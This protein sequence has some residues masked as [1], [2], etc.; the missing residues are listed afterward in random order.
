MVNAMNKPRER[1]S[2]VPSRRTVDQGVPQIEKSFAASSRQRVSL[3][4]S[5]AAAVA[6]PLC[7]A[8][9]APPQPAFI[10]QALGLGLWC[11]V[12]LVL[13]TFPLI[14]AQRS[15]AQW[16][17]IAIW[18][19][20]LLGVAI[21]VLTQ[22]SPAFVV[23]PSAAALGM[24]LTIAWLAQRVPTAWI[25]GWFAACC[26][27]L[28]LAAGYNTFV[29]GLQSVA[30]NWYDEIW[31]A[32]RADDR[33]FGNLRQ[34]NLLAT[35]T[36]WGLLALG[37]LV[38]RVRTSNAARIALCLA[39]VA[40]LIV[41]AATGSRSGWLGLPIAFIAIMLVF[42]HD[43]PL[44]RRGVVLALVVC[45]AVMAIALIS[46]MWITLLR[47]GPLTSS[48]QRLSLWRD[49]LT[50]CATE[51]WLGV[52]FSQ[53]NFAWTL[54]PFA[55]R[56]PNLF[57]HAHSLPLQL[58]VELGLPLTL[59]ILGA[60]VI[61]IAA[62]RFNQ[63]SA[64]GR[65]RWIALGMLGVVLVH[66]LFE[67]PLWFAHFLM[68]TV[69][70]LT[71]LVTRIHPASVEGEAL[72]TATHRASSY[73]PAGLATLGIAALFWAVSGYLNVVDIYRHTAN[74]E[75]AMALATQAQ[76]HWLY[77]YYGDYAAIMLT[78]DGAELP[79]FQRPA[80]AII[81]ERFMVAWSRSLMREGQ[82]ERAAFIGAR[83]REFPAHPLFNE[84]PRVALEP[85]AAAS[86]PRGPSA[87]R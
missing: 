85:G 13:A 33:A 46:V 54:T 48:S 17:N 84:L 75:R 58:A 49:V 28:L 45:A 19:L 53:L 63:H 68:P 35:L 50:L 5:T 39:V 34:P 22:R 43:Q 14:P 77:G 51:P 6:L 72:A 27:G 76:R 18:V 69:L 15:R 86:M 57:D 4:V 44:K 16:A 36:L 11:L 66:S 71:L 61:A 55:E 79:L 70:V 56:T 73:W 30:P 8:Y 40:L 31:I 83:A 23:A 59:L 25:G 12:L 7:I 78:G 87:F 64:L 80:R 37:L 29:T 41:L 74:S 1:K 32:G 21:S 42:A 60:L 47:E 10:S 9:Q 67:Y 2:R 26:V 38:N 65:Y 81:D 82:P 62:E 24:A 52:G 20:L 3:Y